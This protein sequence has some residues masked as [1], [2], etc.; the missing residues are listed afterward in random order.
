MN[1]NPEPTPPPTPDPD[2]RR[3]GLLHRVAHSRLVRLLTGM[4][5]VVSGLADL[6]ENY[7][8]GLNEVLSPTHGLVVLGFVMSAQGI[9]DLIEGAEQLGE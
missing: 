8:E 3:S 2:S 4:L 7:L 6:F 5:L 1:E 9:A